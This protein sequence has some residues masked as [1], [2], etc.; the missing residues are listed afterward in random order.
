MPSL[1]PAAR[2]ADH[3]RRR[4]RSRLDRARIDTY[5]LDEVAGV[6]FP[7]LA[8]LSVLA[9]TTVLTAWALDFTV[10]PIAVGLAGSVLVAVIVGNV[11][12][13]AVAVSLRRHRNT[14]LQSVEEAVKA[15]EQSVVWTADGLCRGARP[16]LPPQADWPDDDQLHGLLGR[17]SNLQ[18]QSAHSLL[19][20]HDESQ[21]AVLVTM[22]QKLARRQH[23]LIGEMLEHLTRQQQGTEDAELLDGSYKIDHLATRLRRMVESVSVVL[24]GEALRE[25]RSPVV[26]SRLLRGAKSEVVKYPRVRTVDGDVGSA[27]A[28]PA[29]VHPDVTHLLAELIDNGLDNSDPASKVIV[30]AQKVAHGLAFE[31]EDRALLPMDPVERDKLNALLKNPSHADIAERVRRGSLGLVTAAKIAEKHGLRVWLSMNET[32]GTTA[33][34]VVPNQYLVPTAPAIASIPVPAGPDPAR[35]LAHAGAPEQPQAGPPEAD[36]LPKR[37]P[38]Q[39]STPPRQKPAGPPPA[40][41]PQAPADWRTGFQAGLQPPRPTQP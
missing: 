25:T 28:L 32:G 23:V 34:V 36:L 35:Q 13:R 7:P 29:H 17:V 11:R 6:L 19:R 20:V 15:A 30:R 21:A 4:R 1:R 33:N 41:N 8:C 26:V 27:F 39:F 40:A 14:E 37:T 5:F 22:Q 2:P 10:V 16:P 24:N 18:L 9:C 31:V 3:R 38:G 12:V